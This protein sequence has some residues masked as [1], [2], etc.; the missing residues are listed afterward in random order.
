MKLWYF[1]A[2]AFVDLALNGCVV[3]TRR[4]YR[5]NVAI[6]ADMAY[7]NGRFDCL[8]Q[9]AAKAED[10]GMEPLAAESAHE[11]DLKLEGKERLP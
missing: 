11:T 2:F 4:A 6:A 1:V 3:M 7:A 5:E 8:E 10:D 9:H